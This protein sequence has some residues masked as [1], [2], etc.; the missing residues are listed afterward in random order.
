ML[1][2][3]SMEGPT[4]IVRSHTYFFA[5]KVTE[6]NCTRRSR[7]RRR[8]RDDIFKSEFTVTV[9]EIYL[10]EWEINNSQ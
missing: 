7:N 2:V 9:W 3:G 6:P 8:S 4:H 5:T 10:M 1:K